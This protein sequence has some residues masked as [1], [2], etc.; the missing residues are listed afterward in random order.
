MLALAQLLLQR[1]DAIAD[2]AALAQISTTDPVAQEVA[3]AR[4]ELAYALSHDI[5]RF[6]SPDVIGDTVEKVMDRLEKVNARRS[7]CTDAVASDQI[8]LSLN[9]L[10]RLREPVDA[11]DDDPIDIFIV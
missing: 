2:K 5:D 8:R 10:K 6:A 9:A 3:K 7:V 11:L 4:Q 1:L